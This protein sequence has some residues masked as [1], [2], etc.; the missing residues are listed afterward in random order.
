MTADTP[1][2]ERPRRH[3]VF[4]VLTSDWPYKTGVIGRAVWPNPWRRSRKET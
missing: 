2:P 1:T 3:G 4:D